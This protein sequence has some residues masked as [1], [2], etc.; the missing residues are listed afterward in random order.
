LKLSRPKGKKSNESRSLFEDTAQPLKVPSEK[1]PAVS[2]SFNKAKWMRR[3]VVTDVVLLPVVLLLV[4]GLKG[5]ATGTT[6][7]QYPTVSQSSIYNAKIYLQQL[8]KSNTSPLPRGHIVDLYGVTPIGTKG[9]YEDV[10]FVAAN[11]SSVAKLTVEMVNGQIVAGPSVQ[12]VEGSV[13]LSSN[14]NLTPWPSVVNLGQAPNTPA[15]TQAINGW[16]TVFTTGTPSALAL[17]VGDPNS[18]HHYSPLHGVTAMQSAEV[19]DYYSPPNSS[20][21]YAEVD[22]TVTER[23]VSKPVTLIYDVLI[24]RPDSSAPAVSAWGPPGSGPTLVPY[25]NGKA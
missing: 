10:A 9:G 22:L 15:F 23:G 20:T 2:K 12:P 14:S 25:Q 13:G 6:G 19:L 18:S 11:G 4:L 24:E 17:A 5:A 7:L 16:A 8:L 1:S 3:V 21:A